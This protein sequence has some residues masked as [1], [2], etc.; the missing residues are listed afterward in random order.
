MARTKAADHAA[1]DLAGVIEEIVQDGATTLLA[2]AAALQARG[3][4]KPRG[5]SAWTATDVRRIE[6]RIADAGQAAD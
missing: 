5:G 2:K 6:A 1:F 3:V 4:L